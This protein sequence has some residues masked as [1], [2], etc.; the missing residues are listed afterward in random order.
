MNQN[1][2]ETPPD[3]DPSEKAS[4]N[5]DEKKKVTIDFPYSDV[6]RSQIPNAFEAVESVA[7]EVTHQ[8]KT[9]GDFK[10]IGLPHPLADFVASQALTSAKKL[11]KKLQEKG[12]LN[13]AKMGLDLAK[14][15]LDKQL[16]NLKKKL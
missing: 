5:Q 14:N 16:D 12:V 7:T 4:E 2:K 1:N 8:W 9:D 11:E 13:L 6:V 15:Q 3:Q 10:N